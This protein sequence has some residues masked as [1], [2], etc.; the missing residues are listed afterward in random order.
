MSLN[1]D[2]RYENKDSDLV[3]IQQPSNKQLKGHQLMSNRCNNTI[4]RNSSNQINQVN[5]VDT[6]NGMTFLIHIWIRMTILSLF[7]NGL[8]IFDG[9][10]PKLHKKCK[11][12]CNCIN[13]S[14]IIIY[15]INMYTISGQV[16][17]E[18]FPDDIHVIMQVIDVPSLIITVSIEFYTIVDAIDQLVLD[19]AVQS[20]FNAGYSRA[21]VVHN[22]CV[23]FILSLLFHFVFFCFFFELV[24]GV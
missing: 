21:K 16:L 22:V 4:S 7:C 11:C 5:I 18:F 15:I 1:Q 9:I 20:S 2:E 19:L 14:K 8:T 13:S 6:F 24:Y 23:V 10:N 17:I 3:M 12:N